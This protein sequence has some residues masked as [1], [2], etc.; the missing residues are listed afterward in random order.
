[1]AS[2]TSGISRSKRV[3]I[4]PMGSAERYQDVLDRPRETFQMENIGLEGEKFTQ[5][6][7]QAST[8]PGVGN[9]SELSRIAGMTEQ[10]PFTPAEQRDIEKTKALSDISSTLTSAAKQEAKDRKTAAAFEATAGVVKAIGGVMNANSKYSSIIGQNN[11]NIQQSKNQALMVAA[12]TKR[13][14]LKEQTKG[15]ARGQEALIAAVAQGQAAG[16]DLA[17]TAISNEDVYA[18]ENM[19]AMEINAMRQIFGLETQQRQIESSGRMAEI[20]RDLE[21]A[22][23]IAGGVFSVASAGI[24]VM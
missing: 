11:F 8:L 2:N 24:G 4:T 22:Q 23:A 12:D 15:K 10:T 9:A 7:A 14:M 18:A 1:M 16:G 6:V 17:Q 5:K 3:R 13:Q 19:M 21:E 20:N